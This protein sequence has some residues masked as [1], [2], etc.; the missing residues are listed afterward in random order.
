VEA[1]THSAVVRAV[2]KGLYDVGVASEVAVQG[3]EVDFIPL[4]WEYVDY[5]FNSE[6]Y[7]EGEYDSILEWLGSPEAREIIEGFSGVRLDRDYLKRLI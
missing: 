3:R 4:R 7:E 6:R 5:I 1:R 2:E